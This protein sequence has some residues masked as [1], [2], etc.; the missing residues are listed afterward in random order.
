MGACPV[1]CRG[2]ESGSPAGLHP[3]GTVY[4]SPRHRGG[5]RRPKPAA[6]GAPASRHRNLRLWDLHG[7]FCRPRPHRRPPPGLP[8]LLDSENAHRTADAA[9]R[10]TASAC[11]APHPPSRDVDPQAVVAVLVGM[12]RHQRTAGFRSEAEYQQFVSDVTLPGTLLTWAPIDAEALQKN[13]G[14]WRSLGDAIQRLDFLDDLPQ[15]LADG[16]PML[17][18]EDLA[19][20]GIDYACLGD[21]SG[22]NALRAFVQHTCSRISTSL[23]D[24]RGI[25]PS[26]RRFPKA[27]LISLMA[28]TRSVSR[29][30]AALTRSNSGFGSGSVLRGLLAART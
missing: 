30:G 1:R 8:R 6:G 9:V 26:T 21:A 19:A 28:R 24:T 15:D 27:I 12:S 22:T 5:C 13:P 7:R 16:R 29:K 3:R 18:H 10:V 20:Y 17:I 14:A 2:A 11:L 25:I 23:H 4:G